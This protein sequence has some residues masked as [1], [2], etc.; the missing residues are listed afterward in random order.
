MQIRAPRFVPLVLVIL[1]AASMSA[2]SAEAVCTRTFDGG[3]STSSWHDAA[4]WDLDTLPISTDTVCIGAAFAVTYSTGST[5]IVALEHT[6]TQPFTVS[7]GTLTISGTSTISSAGLDQTGGTLTGTG[8]LDIAGLFTWSGGTQSGGITNVNGG[9]TVSGS[10]SKTLTARTLNSPGAVTYSGAGSLTIGNGAI[11]NNN[12]AF[13]LQTDADLPAGGGAPSTFNNPGAFTKS[14]GALTSSIGVAFN[15]VGTLTASSG[16]LSL[17]NGGNCGATCNGGY[18]AI[19]PGTLLFNGGTFGLGPGSSVAGAGMVTFG[20]GTV[21]HAGTNNVAGATTVDGGTVNFTGTVLSVGTLSLSAGTADFSSGETVTPVGTVTHVGGTLTGSDTLTIAGLYDWSGG[22]HSGGGTTNA[23]GGM[24]LAG[25]GFKTLLGRTLNNNGAAVFTGTGS[26]LLGNGA[27]FNNNS[28][29]DLQ[30]DANV[31]ATLSLPRTFNNV[32]TFTKSAGAQSDVNIEFNNSGTVNASAGILRLRSGGSCGGA[33]EGT[34]DVPAALT[35]ST[36]GSASTFTL[37]ASSLV[38]GAGT[39][40]F[41]AATVNLAGTYNVTGAT[42]ATNGCM[43]NF[44]G[45]VL[46]VGTLTNSGGTAN[47]SSGDVITPMITVAGGGDPGIN[48]DTFILSGGTLTGSDTITIAGMFNWSGGTQSGT[49]VTN[50]NGG[51]SVNG[52][53]GKTLGRTLNNTGA[54]TMTGTGPL[55]VIANG[56][57]ENSGTFDIQSDADFLV[58]G[59]TGPRTIN[60][61]GTFS[62]SAGTDSTIAPDFNTSGTVSVASGSALNFTGTFGQSGGS[63]RTCFTTAPP[64]GLTLLAGSF[65]GVPPGPCTVTGNINNTGGTMVVGDGMNLPVVITLN[66]TYTQGGGASFTMPVGGTTPGGTANN[67]G[68]LNIGSG[69]AILGGTLNVVLINGF[70]P[71]PGNS[72]NP[73]NYGSRAGSF[74]NIILPDIAPNFWHVTQGPTSVVLSVVASGDPVINANGSVNAASFAPGGAVAPGSIAAIFGSNL[75]TSTATAL[76]IPLPTTLGGATMQFNGNQLVPKFFATDAQINIQIPWELQ[77]AS[78]ANLTDTVNAVT[79]PAEPVSLAMFAPGLFST[80]QNGMGQGAILIANT[81]TFAAPVGSIPGAQSRAAM[82]GVDFLE[83]YCT[84]LGAV[85]NQ[86]ATGAAA[87]ANPLSATTGNTS[88]TIGGVP[89]TVL[90]SGLAPG[91]VGLYVVTLQVPAGAPVGNAVN[92]ILTIGGVQSNTVTIAVE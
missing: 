28:T 22:T 43:A 78:V 42:V 12:G 38:A 72:F 86:P 74:N 10:G 27:V 15:N 2:G 71:Q 32:G 30:T 62:K 23:N 14:G 13:D 92:V 47:F 33:C 45:T 5:T 75:A 48:T 7:G 82:R 18:N 55:N 46:A 83:I 91:F 40:E 20:S 69:M 36:G 52:S 31:T 68:Q 34:F 64:S 29:F 79:S 73:L 87:S 53:L 85:T 51:L 41:N 25:N 37:G 77:G 17:T 80:N 67:F 58:G 88:V 59:L 35:F 11:F 66:S 65:F 70:V 3:A 39:V 61:T 57:L 50:A 76:A 16:I 63:T 60:N 24:T 56:V 84:G 44:T 1:A 9:L 19:A 6:S 49:G 90:F 89:A 81:A 8:T 54:G 26:L 4:N 21:N